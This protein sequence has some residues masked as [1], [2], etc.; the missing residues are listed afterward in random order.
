[1][2]SSACEN[3]LRDARRIDSKDD[4]WQDYHLCHKRGLRATARSAHCARHDPACA[5]LLDGWAHEEQR[6]TSPRHIGVVVSDTRNR[7]LGGIHGAADLIWQAFADV[8]GYT[9]IRLHLRKPPTKLKEPKMWSDWRSSRQ[10]LLALRSPAYRSLDLFMYTELDQ[11]P[12]APMARLEP[13]FRATGVLQDGQHKR[14]LTRGIFMAVV[15]EYPCRDT[16]SG[17]S[18]NMGNF[19]FRRSPKMMALLHALA[20][21]TYNGGEAAPTWPARQGAF[22]DDPRVYSSFK[23]HIRVL[24]SG[25]PLGSPYGLLVSHLTGGLVDRAF[26]PDR[27]KHVWLHVIAPCVRAALLKRDSSSRCALYPPWAGGACTTCSQTTEFHS[28]EGTAHRISTRGCCGSLEG[29]IP[30]SIVQRHFDAR[31]PSV[32]PI[33]Q[34]RRALDAL[35]VGE[36]ALSLLRSA[37]LPCHPSVKHPR[38]CNLTSNP[39]HQWYREDPVQFQKERE[40]R[41]GSHRARLCEEFRSQNDTRAMLMYKCAEVCVRHTCSK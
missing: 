35:D 8:H 34:L 33:G 22:S 37:K 29:Q 3:N 23:R 2:A 12:V 40:R 16:R 30:L 19:L 7:N 18:F 5:E 31:D 38:Y 36:L 13:L 15:E 41:V 32:W 1:M 39:A 14:N 11:W 25:C 21:S 4:K 26:D 6:G 27:A 17:G 28:L 24:P 9:Y 20:S 10:L